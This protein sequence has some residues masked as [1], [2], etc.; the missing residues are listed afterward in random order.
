MYVISASHLMTHIRL[1]SS[2][3]PSSLLSG[4]LYERARVPSHQSSSHDA[5]GSASAGAAVRGGCA[6]RRQR[7][8]GRH[9]RFWAG[10]RQVS[11]R[12]D[13]RTLFIQRTLGMSIFNALIIKIF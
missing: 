12:G 9:S 5:G 11:T 2:L 13:H 10:A 6:G 4:R 3:G 8:E 1:H 7:H